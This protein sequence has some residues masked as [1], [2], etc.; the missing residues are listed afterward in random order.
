MRLR[1]A[2]CPWMMFQTLNCT[3]NCSS[4][5]QNTNTHTGGITELQKITSVRLL[6]LLFSCSLS[7]FAINTALAHSA[8]YC[9][10]PPRANSAAECGAAERRDAQPPSERE[11]E[12]FCIWMAQR[13]R[14]DYDAKHPH[15]HTRT[16]THTHTQTHVIYTTAAAWCTKQYPKFKNR[17]N[18]DLC[19]CLL[20]YHTRYTLFLYTNKTRR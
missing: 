17:A 9:A 14:R 15:K 8:R 13:R 12:R 19:E 7:H 1:G 3:Q 4:E 16:F 11:R 2:R 5:L 10:K 6:R 20:C 18:G